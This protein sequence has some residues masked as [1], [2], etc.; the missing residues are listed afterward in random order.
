M[1]EMWT[2]ADG[3]QLDDVLESF[4]E[5]HVVYAPS[6]GHDGRYRWLRADR[7][8][9]DRH[10]LAPYRPT[11]PLKSLLLAP[12]EQI[13]VLDGP[14]APSTLETPV[15]TRMVLGVKSCDLASLKVQDHVFLDGGCTDP[16]YARSRES[17][18][19]VSCDCTS[20]LEVCFCPVVGQQPYAEDGFDI[21]IAPTPRGYCIESGSARGSAL[22]DRA[23]AALAPA[24]DALLEARS[25]ERA[26]LT[27]TLVDHGRATTGLEP[28]LDL[29]R[30]VEDTFDSKLWEAFAADCVECGA[31][32]FICCTCHCF[33]LVDGRDDAGRAA[34]WK[35]WD[36]CLFAGFARTAGG[37]T[38]RPTRASRLRNRFD[39]KFVYFPQAIGDYACDGCGRCTEACIGRIDIREVLKRAVD[40]SVALHADSGDDRAD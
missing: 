10:T 2:V 31:C 11:E 25:D 5:G 30:A 28:G 19:V 27:S 4:S 22:I 36:S 38:P 18:I 8:L 7:W 33:S 32:N 23:G 9:R 13:G 17:T 21:N 20:H 29:R 16:H 40:E 1:H 39:K 3:S 26:Q 37:G 24:S 14:G 34:R 15:E 35:Q 12:R 6:P